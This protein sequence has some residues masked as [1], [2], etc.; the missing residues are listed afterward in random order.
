MRLA[1]DDRYRLTID[2]LDPTWTE[3]QADRLPDV[4]GMPAETGHHWRDRDGNRV[5]GYEP[6]AYCG[7]CGWRLDVV[8]PEPAAA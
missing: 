2:D 4:H 7:L 5:D 1:A 3:W 8:D 6:G